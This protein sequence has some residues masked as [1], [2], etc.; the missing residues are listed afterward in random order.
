[1][2]EL[3]VC[4]TLQFL[5]FYDLRETLF[6]THILIC[7]SAIYLLSTIM[8]KLYRHEHSPMLKASLI[9][10]VILV[11][12][13]LF[14]LAVYYSNTAVSDTSI[15]VRLGFLAFIF[16][17][18]R[19]SA[20]NSLDLMEKGRQ[21]E[22]YQKLAIIDMLTGLNNRN[23]YISD[24]DTL[25]SS[26]D[27]MIVT[28]DLNNLKKCNDSLGHSEGDH[29]ILNAANIIQEVF[30]PYGS[31]YRIGG[32]EFCVV[33]KNASQ[34]PISQLIAL[35]EE[36]EQKF[37][38]DNPSIHMHISYGYAIY[39]HTMDSDLE[40][41]RDRADALMYENKRKSKEMQRKPL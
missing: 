28:F 11:S 16:I 15:I 24:I 20:K 12:S 35:L 38:T 1:M 10:F 41:T 18:S 19:E 39:D 32:D 14:N 21:A 33:I 9:A 2:I 7:L 25:A 22:L 13:L 5:D 29:Y 34:C 6:I 30:S 31:C 40:K 3:A 4:L 8:I 26:Q 37:N 27:I 23:A 36:K 17:L